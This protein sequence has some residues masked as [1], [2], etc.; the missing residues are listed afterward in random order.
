MKKEEKV[1]LWSERIQKFYSSGQTCRTWCLEHQIPVSTMSYWIRKLKNAGMIST[2][3]NEPVFAKMPTEQ[4]LRI[5][6]SVSSQ[7]S[8]PV[9]IFLTES[10]R[11][12]VSPS[13]P[14]E[15]LA[16]IIK[17]LRYHA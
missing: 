10:I 17:E 6:E 4:E 16:T 13:C 7:T 14:A 5:K 2:K 12:E 1:L 15:L 11:I 8:S 9:H 3:E